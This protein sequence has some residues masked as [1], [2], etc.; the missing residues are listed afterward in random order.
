MVLVMVV[1]NIKH[2]CD[3]M[4][5]FFAVVV[6]NSDIVRVINELVRQVVLR[7]SW[8][9]CRLWSPFKNGH[10]SISFLQHL[11]LS[12]WALIQPRQEPMSSWPRRS[13]PNIRSAVQRFTNCK[14][15]T[16]VKMKIQFGFPLHLGAL[17]VPPPL[18]SPTHVHSPHLIW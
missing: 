6:S 8:R 14:L 13:T 9:P 5:F 2:I 10:P 18:P 11:Y 4:F 12:A 1:D 15:F 7:A 3:A 17:R 16:S